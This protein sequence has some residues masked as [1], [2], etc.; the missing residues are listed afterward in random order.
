[1]HTLKLGGTKVEGLKHLAGLTS[2][3]EFLLA[4][5]KVADVGLKELAGL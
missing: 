5:T 2:L 1:L 3:Q 4:N